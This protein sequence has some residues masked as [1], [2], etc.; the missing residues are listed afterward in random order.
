[1]LMRIRGSEIFELL[2]QK[3][4]MIFVCGG[5]QGIAQKGNDALTDILVEHGKMQRPDALNLL[6]KWMGEKRYLRDL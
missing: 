3:E 4:A 6:V 1:N 5:A 2:S